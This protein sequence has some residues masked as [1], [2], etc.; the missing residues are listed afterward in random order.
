MISPMYSSA[1]PRLLSTGV[2]I[3]AGRECGEQIR[4][5]SKPSTG[6]GRS[7]GSAIAWKR[8]AWIVVVLH[9]SPTRGGKILTQDSPRPRCPFNFRQMGEDDEN[10][11]SHDRDG[12]TC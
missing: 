11:G 1:S 5:R 12:R 8:T 6:F 10:P 4:E 2:D 7:T 9:C 3:S